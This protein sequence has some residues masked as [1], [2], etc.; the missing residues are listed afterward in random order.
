MSENKGDEMLIEMD[1][2]T[3]TS[4]MSLQVDFQ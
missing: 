2:V 1:Y 3:Q 4:F